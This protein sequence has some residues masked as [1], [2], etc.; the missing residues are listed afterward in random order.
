M[1]YMMKLKATEIGLG[2]Y[3]ELSLADARKKHF[4]TR[5]LNHSPTEPKT[6]FRF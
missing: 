2:R 4:K 3:P 5:I 6:I 1:R